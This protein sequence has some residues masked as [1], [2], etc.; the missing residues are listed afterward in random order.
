MNTYRL[1]ELVE[2]DSIRILYAL[3]T[4][5]LSELVETIVLKCGQMHTFVN[6]LF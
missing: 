2:E 3:N 4:H 5:R 1:S 6:T